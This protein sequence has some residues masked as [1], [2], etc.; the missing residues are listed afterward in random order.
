MQPPV[1]ATL[2]R[3]D[4]ETFKFSQQRCVMLWE[5]KELSSEF[6]Q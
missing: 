2:V 4:L 3:V 6:G 1:V 5:K